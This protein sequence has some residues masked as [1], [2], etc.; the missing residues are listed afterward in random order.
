MNRI[1]LILIVIF[2][3]GVIILLYPFVSQY[4]NSL[5]QSA[6]VSLYDEMLSEKDAISYIDM[7]DSANNYNRELLR[8]DFPLVQYKEITG[9]MNILDINNGMM[10]YITIDKIGVEIPI[11]HGTSSSVLNVGVGHLEGSSLPIGGEGTH[12]VLSGHSGMPTSKLFTDLH[13][14][15]IGDIFF[16]TVIDRKLKYMVDNIVVV[17]PNDTSNLRI[18]EDSDYVT[19]ITCTP[20]GL[21][22]Y[23][24]LVR[25][26]RVNEIVKEEVVI[27]DEA[28][29]IDKNI[30]ALVIFGIVFCIFILGLVIKK[31]LTL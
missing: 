21:N 23:R 14:L 28:F 10:G 7:F 25:G 22:T 27:R 9:Y 3:V 26:S 8:L 2:L 12:S 11:Y 6:A 31:M 5:V 4:W 30:V 1:R 18:E 17:N 16:I 19:L 13:K 20:Y 29:L 15:E 24:L